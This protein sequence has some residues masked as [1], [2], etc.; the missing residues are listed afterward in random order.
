[1]DSCKDSSFYQKPYLGV[2]L[3]ASEDHEWHLHLGSNTQHKWHLINANLIFEAFNKHIGL[4]GRVHYWSISHCMNQPGDLLYIGDRWRAML[5][6]VKWF[7]CGVSSV[8]SIYWIPFGSRFYKL[9]TKN[10]SWVWGILFSPFR[11][12]YHHSLNSGFYYSFL[13]LVLRFTCWLNVVERHQMGYYLFIN[14]ILKWKPERQL[15]S[16]GRARRSLNFRRIAWS[17]DAGCSTIWLHYT[18][19]VVYEKL[20]EKNLSNKLPTETISDFK[21]L[22]GDRV[23]S[24]CSSESLTW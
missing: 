8:D 15:K 20:Y 17:S 5:I 21:R 13:P 9:V 2:K 6:H 7:D 24:S 14:T 18:T 16:P 23:S 4:S 1:M 12:E 11:C 22:S 19:A 10:G 3:A